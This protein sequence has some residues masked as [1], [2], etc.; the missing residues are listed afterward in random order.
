MEIKAEVS[1]ALAELGFGNDDVERILATVIPEAESL[2][3]WEKGQ[4]HAFDFAF[5]GA[6]CKVAIR[7][8]GEQYRIVF[9]LLAEWRIAKGEYRDH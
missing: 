4:I 9:G 3:E 1:P 8:A 6:N 7:H 5:A 2:D